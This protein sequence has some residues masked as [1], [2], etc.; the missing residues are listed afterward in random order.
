MKPGVPLAAVG[1]AS[2]LFLAITSGRYV[3]SGHVRV[4]DEIDPQEVLLKAN[5]MLKEGLG[6]F[7]SHAA[8]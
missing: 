7:F 3:F 2:S 6:F 4:A 5:A 8:G 1:H